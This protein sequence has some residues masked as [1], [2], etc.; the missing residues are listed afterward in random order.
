MIFGDRSLLG[1]LALTALDGFDDLLD[2][3][4]LW[5]AFGVDGLR[6]L[7]DFIGVEWAA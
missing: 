5:L 3:E 1:R 4:L 7:E 2:D 6:E